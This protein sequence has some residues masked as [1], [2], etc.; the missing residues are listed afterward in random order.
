MDETAETSLVM[1]ERC[2]Y[3]WVVVDHKTLRCSYP[4]EM[5]EP[6]HHVH[7]NG[8]FY[9]RTGWFPVRGADV[10]MVFYVR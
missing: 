2:L 8:C 5:G 4:L 7:R 10:G 3:G 1:E 9:V 6:P